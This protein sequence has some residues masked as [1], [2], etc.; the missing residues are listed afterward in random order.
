MSVLFFPNNDFPKGCRW[1]VPPSN[2]MDICT[3][4][5]QRDTCHFWT[6]FAPN[7][8]CKHCAGQRMQLPLSVQCGSVS[9]SFGLE[10][11]F[12]SL[13]FFS[14]DRVYICQLRIIPALIGLCQSDMANS[15]NRILALTSRLR[16]QL[17]TKLT[18]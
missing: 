17:S 1:I 7:E 9:D 5:F 11:A 6:Q 2:E 18:S 3:L 13:V 12:A 16:R 15:V 10:I 4:F 14:A 8:Q